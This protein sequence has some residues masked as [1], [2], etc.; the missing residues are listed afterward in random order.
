MA[1]TFYTNPMSRGQIAR[2]ALHEV[3]ADYSQSLV[4]YG[5]EMKGDYAQN[6]NPMGKVPAI[7]HDGKI[8]TECAA[9]CHYLAEA[10]PEAGLLPNAD[11]KADYFRWLFFAAGPVEAAVTNNSMGFTVEDPQKRGL[12]GYGDYDLV[13]AVLEDKLA[14]DDFVCGNRFTMADV[15]VGSHVIWGMQF[16]SMPPRESFRAYS[17][18]LTDRDA[19]K[20]AKAIDMK[21]IEAAQTQA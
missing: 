15:Y 17:E 14:T 18:R 2:W 7:N 5:E 9:I 4:G 6:V 13:M 8:V 21:L 19:Y 11:E 12:L 1:I 16:G 20:T 3:N 10:H